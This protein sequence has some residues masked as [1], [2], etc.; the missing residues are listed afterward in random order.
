LG[1]DFDRLTDRQRTGIETRGG[2]ASAVINVDQRDNSDLVINLSGQEF[3]WTQPLDFL[4]DGAGFNVNVTHIGQSL[5]GDVPAGLNPNALLAG[6]APWT[7]NATAYWETRDFQVRVSFVHRDETLAGVGPDNNIQHDRYNIA[8]DYLDA[9][10]S[11]PLPFYRQAS[12]T[13]QAQNLLKQVQ[14]SRFDKDEARA[15]NF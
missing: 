3:Q 7:Y 5:S 14:L 15:Y 11:F 4:L 1:I 2:P 6:L 12:F 13:I 8:S 10:V 9:Q